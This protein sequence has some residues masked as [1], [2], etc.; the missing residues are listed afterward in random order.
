[1]KEEWTDELEHQV[2][3]E[4]SGLSWVDMVVALGMLGAPDSTMKRAHE[5]WEFRFLYGAPGPHRIPVGILSSKDV[6]K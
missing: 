3:A 4:V 6:T 5:A 1:M 2:L